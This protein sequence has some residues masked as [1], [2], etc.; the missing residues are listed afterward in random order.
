MRRL[1]LL[2]ACDSV[3]HHLPK[4]VHRLEEERDE[5]AGDGKRPIPQALEGVLEGVGEPR[6]PRVPQR[7]GVPLEGVRYP[8]DGLQGFLVF[9]L[10]LQGDECFLHFAEVLLRLVQ[11]RMQDRLVIDVHLDGLLEPPDPS[12]SVV[13]LED[14]LTSPLTTHVFR[15]DWDPFSFEE[16]AGD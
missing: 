3:R 11:E 12:N 14:H 1:H 16:L 6:H 2:I 15:D 7:G 9:G 10:G 4:G 8:E 13:R 5:A